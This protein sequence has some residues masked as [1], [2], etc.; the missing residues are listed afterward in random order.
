MFNKYY[1]FMKNQDKVDLYLFKDWTA[2]LLLK[3]KHRT[4]I[5]FVLK[6]FSELM[7]EPN[8]FY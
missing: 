5:Q 2:V 1:D 4:F 3:L 6:E 8:F 7:N